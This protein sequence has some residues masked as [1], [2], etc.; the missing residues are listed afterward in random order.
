M[1]VGL[2]LRILVLLASAIIWYR[3]FI[4]AHISR[5]QLLLAVP[6]LRYKYAFD[7]VQSGLT[8]EFYA[9][10]ITR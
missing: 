8:C 10:F 6:T 5:I 9:C 7:E 4:C 3:L 1:F 2:E